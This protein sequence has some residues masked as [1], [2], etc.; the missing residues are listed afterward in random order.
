MEK[1]RAKH[2]DHR[3]RATITIGI[4]GA[5][6]SRTEDITSKTGLCQSYLH[7][8]L[9]EG[10][11]PRCPVYFVLLF[12]LP[13]SPFVSYF[14]SV[15]SPPASIGPLRPPIETPILTEEIDRQKGPERNEGNAYEY[16]AHAKRVSSRK[17]AFTRSRTIILQEYALYFEILSLPLYQLK[18]AKVPGLPGSS[19]W[20]FG[21]VSLEMRKYTLKICMDYVEINRQL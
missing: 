4:G 18:N 11:L 13:P 1:K 9:L 8:T 14:P 3:H 16:R 21:L 7:R 15:S 6:I 12:L 10:S 5:H 20:N 2:H 17:L 19:P